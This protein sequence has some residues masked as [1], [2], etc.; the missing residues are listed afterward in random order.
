MTAAS[1]GPRESGPTSG[2]TATFP[3]T[4]WSYW[5][6]I[7]CF[8]AMFGWERSASS[9]SGT[10]RPAR[11]EAGA[12][13]TGVVLA[14]YFVATGD[15]ASQAIRRIRRLRPASIETDDGNEGPHSIIELMNSIEDG[16]EQLAR[17]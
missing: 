7:Q 16:R 3:C 12:G 8:E 10:E 6:M 5:R 17:G 4:S 9:D 14:C 13:R 1:P 11:A 15:T 2:L